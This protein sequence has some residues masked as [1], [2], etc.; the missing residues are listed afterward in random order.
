MP[1]SVKFGS[2]P[3]IFWMR[4]YSSAVRPCSAASSGVTLISVSNIDFEA[5]KLM[6]TPVAQAP[7]CGV[8]CLQDLLCCNQNPQAEAC[9]TYPK[10][11]QQRAASAIRSA[12][13]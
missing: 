12:S 5:D 13:E 4:E 10:P 7:A 3:R 9:A 6:K 1:S 8:S 11:K 2:R